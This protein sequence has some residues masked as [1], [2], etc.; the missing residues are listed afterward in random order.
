VF[1]PGKL[2]LEGRPILRT[3]VADPL[4]ALP[5]T[6][7]AA[8]LLVCSS[9]AIVSSSSDWWSSSSSSSSASSSSS[10][11]HLKDAHHSPFCN[12]AL[13]AKLYQEPLSHLLN[14]K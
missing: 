12:A 9:L 4:F 3:R 2:R 14:T 6:V 13:A 8:L 1:N 10:E 7:T 11:D 5:V